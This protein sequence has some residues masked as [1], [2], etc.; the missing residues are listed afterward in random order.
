MNAWAGLILMLLCGGAALAG[1][2]AFMMAR[3]L[4]RPPRMTDAKANWLL[5]RLTPGDLGLGFEE[6][7]FDVRDQRGGGLLKL[8][9]WWIPH[10][11][12]GGRCVVL[13]HGY[14]DAKVGAIAWAPVFHG[15]RWN[16]LAVDLRGHGESAG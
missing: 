15:L 12:A 3:V 11:S 10:A 4:T 13:V 14:A 1:G 2:A 9:A 7:S 5:K 16:V 8:A 6:M